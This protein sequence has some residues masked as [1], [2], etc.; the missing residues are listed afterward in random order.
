MAETYDWMPVP[1]HQASRVSYLFRVSDCFMRLLKHHLLPA[2]RFPPVLE[3][4]PLKGLG[5]LL[6]GMRQFRRRG[7]RLA[8]E[9]G[10]RGGRR[11]PRGPWGP[12]GGGAAGAA[13]RGGVVAVRSA[14]LPERA[15]LPPAVKWRPQSGVWLNTDTVELTVKT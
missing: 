8:F 2:E 1:H 9:G 12:R 15:S 14:P 13:R 4:T 6:R 10:R 11:G 3:D 7:A 5:R